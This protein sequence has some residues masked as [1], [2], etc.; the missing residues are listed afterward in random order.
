MNDPP[1]ADPNGEPFDGF[2]VCPALDRHRAACRLASSDQ[3]P[4]VPYCA[5]DNDR[6]K[7]ERRSELADLTET[8]D[9][10][11]EPP[12]PPQQNE[13]RSD[14]ERASIDQDEEPDEGQSQE[15]SMRGS[16]KH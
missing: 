12:E 15:R 2:I 13:D 7:V 5:R 6:D 8:D 3:V 16:R 4:N 10:R 1:V 9:N 11:N 14:R